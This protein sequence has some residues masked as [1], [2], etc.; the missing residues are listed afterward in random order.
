MAFRIFELLLGLPWLV[1][2]IV[3]PVLTVAGREDVERFRAGAQRSAEGGFAL[4]V[5]LVV[6]LEI[7]AT[8]LVVV[9]GGDDFAGAAPILRIQVLALLPLILSQVFALSLLAVHL[10]RYLVVLSSIG[11]CLVVGLGVGFFLLWGTWGAAIA[12]VV[13]ETVLAGLCYLFLLRL[14]PELCPSLRFVWRAALAGALASSAIA[15]PGLPAFAKAA[16][17]ASIYL[18]AAL[19]LRALPPDVLAAVRTAPVLLRLAA[20]LPRRKPPL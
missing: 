18:V 16:V 10:E 17:A 1:L 15:L 6:V 14:K 12:G 19:A 5:L 8:A 7:V 4:A 9:I 2:A 20:A 13:A 3:L 11:F